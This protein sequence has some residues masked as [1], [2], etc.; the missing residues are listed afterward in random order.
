MIINIYIFNFRQED[1]I[2]F[3]ATPGDKPT[4]DEQNKKSDEDEEEEELY[5]I[6][7]KCVEYEQTI[8]VAAKIVHIDFEGRSDG[9]SIKQIVLALKPR[10]LI[11]VRGNPYSTK[12]VY[13]FAKVFIDGKVFTPRIG[14]C[15]NVTTESHI[16]QV[17]LNLNYI[18]FNYL[19]K[20]NNNMMNLGTFDRCTTFQN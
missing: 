12:V 5:D 1:F 8:Y 19:K 2:K 20:N 16:Y 3:D 17:K 10:R 14:Q 4:V 13:N 15:L 7:S 6:P 18:R 11:L 9:E